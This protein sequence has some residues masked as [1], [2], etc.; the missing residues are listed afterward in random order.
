MPG[1][2]FSSKL[3]NPLIAGDNFLLELSYAIHLCKG[4]KRLATFGKPAWLPGK[5][6][7]YKKEFGGY[8]L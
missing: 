1:K 5:P 6:R 7:S 2:D 8:Q 3:S 4:F